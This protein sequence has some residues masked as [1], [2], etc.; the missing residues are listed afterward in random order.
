MV[1]ASI[2]LF[3]VAAARD[4]RCAVVGHVEVVE[5]ARVDHVPRPGEI[6]QTRGTWTE[7]AG[8]GA[9]AAAALQRLAGDV[10]FF[11]VFG[12]DELGHRAE[13]DLREHGLRVECVY[14]DEPQ[15]RG[16]TYVDAGG[17]RTITVIGRKLVPHADD[18]LP[19]AELDEVAGVYF[20]GGDPA[21]LREARRARALVATARELPT[22]REARVELDALTQSSTDE[23]ERYHPGDLDPAPR[24]VVTTEGRKGGHYVEGDRT[25]RWLAA[26]LPGPLAD[27]YGAGD[28]FAAALAFALGAGK[29][30]DDA[31]DIAAENAA[32]AMT[33]PGAGISGGGR[34]E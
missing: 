23:S 11:T 16:F 10:T 28:S 22:L 9:V 27:T 30:T 8:G 31:L 5:F 19:W 14:R 25:G 24:R 29:S 32:V 4:V 3:N 34:S 26:P 33:R 7:P 6:I 12:D 2:M 17:E 15:R 21:A 20:C 1:T 18:P 13:R